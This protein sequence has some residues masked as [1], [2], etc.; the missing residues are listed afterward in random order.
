M[1]I[2]LTGFEP[3]A[4][5]TRNP[6]GEIAES[7]SGADIDGAEVISAVLP[8]AFGEDMARIAPL[9]ERHHPEAIVSLGLGGRVPALH[10][11]RVAINL[12]VV[13]D[14]DFPI[15]EGPQAYFATLPTRDMVAAIREAG[16]PATLH[17]S[18]GTFLCNHVMYSVLHYLRG[19]D[20]DVPAGF[21]HL[22][23]LPGQNQ[24]D[25]EGEP[26]GGMALEM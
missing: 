7:L 14:Q 10:V 17:Y 8:V 6:S 4:N 19:M 16:V 25:L 15:L 20:L 24:E 18:A 13:D 26:K 3:W 5:W 2:L 23:R 22:P 11:E 1:K 21:I 9:I 12:K